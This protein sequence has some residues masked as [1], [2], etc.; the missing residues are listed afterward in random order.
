MKSFLRRVSLPI[1]IF[2][3][4]V[5]IAAPTV[6]AHHPDLT[7]S[8]KVDQRTQV[9]GAMLEPNTNYVLKVL[10]SDTDRHIVQIFSQDQSRMLTTFLGESDP[11]TG[12]SGFTFIE[13]QG[14][15][16]KVVREWSTP[17]HMQSGQNFS[18]TETVWYAPDVKS[19]VRYT[20]TN[21]RAPDTWE[22]NSY[23]L[24]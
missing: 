11:T 17:R 6:F 16:P 19:V 2:A 23:S 24:R 20:S 18:W 9:P 15:Q 4:V 1:A 8:F 10:K 7:N 21:P 14:N 5:L 3:W 13:M 12:Q 22:L